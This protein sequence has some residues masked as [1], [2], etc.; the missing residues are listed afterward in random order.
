MCMPHPT[1]GRTRPAA[2]L[3]PVP[4][5][6]APMPRHAS[7]TPLITPQTSS[8]RR[9]E[10]QTVNLRKTA[11]KLLVAQM[12]HH[13]LST[14]GKG[15][16]GK[17]PSEAE[18]QQQLADNPGAVDAAAQALAQQHSNSTG[19]VGQHVAWQATCVPAASA[20]LELEAWHRLHLC[21]ISD[22]WVLAGN[23]AFSLHDDGRA[24][25]MSNLLLV[26]GR[27]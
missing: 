5:P 19:Q 21:C 12:R 26:G 6:D 20:L 14:H 3:D 13:A 11:E 17:A 9:R 25:S 18:L 8:D 7:D 23:A 2:N 4:H 1:L 22:G 24:S 27:A 10:Q 15:R 16:K